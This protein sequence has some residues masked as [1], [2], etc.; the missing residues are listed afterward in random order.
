MSL[1][2]KKATKQS[3]KLRLAVVGPPGSGKTYT[4]LVLATALGKKVAVIDTER[5][6]ASKYAHLFAFDVLELDRFAPQTYV[7]AIKAAAQAGYDVLVI[8]S[9]S[10]AWVG[11]G[12][13]LEMHDNAVA[14]QS[15]K[16]TWSAWR[17]VTPQHYALIDAIVQAPLHVIATMR[18]KTEYVQEKDERTGKPVVR[19]VGLAPVQRDGMEY[20][21]DIVGEMDAEHTLVVSKSRCPELTDAV[22]RKPGPELAKHLLDW[23]GAGAESR[24]Q[25]QKPEPALTVQQPAPT[26][27]PAANEKP[28]KWVPEDH[29]LD[30]IRQIHKRLRERNSR[31]L[32]ALKY[33]I[34]DDTQIGD[35]FEEPDL[36]QDLTEAQAANFAARMNTSQCERVLAAMSKPKKVPA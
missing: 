30:L 27:A 21:F 9:L 14:K 17:D 8:D 22:V 7:E 33:G 29:H 4:G 31:W 13:A 5:G 20:E 2:F 11:R 36:T 28:K 10:H 12:G 6:S 18:A 26:P 3:A 19:K 34:G 16:N 25:A 1:T 35:A 24:Q 15:S 23:L 32:D